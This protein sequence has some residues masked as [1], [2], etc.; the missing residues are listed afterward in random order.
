MGRA[1]RSEQTRHPASRTLRAAVLGAVVA[2]ALVTPT[3]AVLLKRDAEAGPN[4]DRLDVMIWAAFA[5]L[6]VLP[7]CAGVACWLLGLPR[8]WLVVL[9]GE[10]L[11]TVVL[12]V[13]HNTGPHHS[14]AWVY[15]LQGA[16]A[17][18]LAAGL[19]ALLPSRYPV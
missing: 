15:G 10:L 8:P 18:G 17:F 14:P 1:D 2:F 16:T 13:G 4:F 3:A 11:L 19:T 12:R 9:L 7:V 5:Y 6:L